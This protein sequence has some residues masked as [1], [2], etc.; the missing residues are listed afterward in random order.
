MFLLTINIVSNNYARLLPPRVRVL[1]FETLVQ[2]VQTPGIFV[3]YLKTIFNNIYLRVQHN[4][5]G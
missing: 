3:I 2:M 1:Q 5:I 4:Q